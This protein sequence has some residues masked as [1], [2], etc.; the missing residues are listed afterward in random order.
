M[1]AAEAGLTQKQ[2]TDWFTNQCKRRGEAHRRDRNKI[3]GMPSIGRD[4]VMFRQGKR[5]ALCHSRPAECD[6]T[7]PFIA[8]IQ[9][10]QTSPESLMDSTV[11]SSPR[12]YQTAME[13]S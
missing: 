7:F 13:I 5:L 1:L 8:P 12:G 9:T 2:V 10:A 6:G 11:G 4:D 3:G